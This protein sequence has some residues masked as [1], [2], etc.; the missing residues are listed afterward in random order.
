MLIVDVTH[1]FRFD[2]AR[3]MLAVKVRPEGANLIR[4]SDVDVKK[5]MTGVLSALKNKIDEIIRTSP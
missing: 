2:D 1:S 4:F 3:F 5:N